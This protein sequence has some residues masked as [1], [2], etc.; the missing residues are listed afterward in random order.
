MS[1]KTTLIG[2]TAIL[3]E[4]GFKWDVAHCMPS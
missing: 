1:K 2:Y 4:E 3:M